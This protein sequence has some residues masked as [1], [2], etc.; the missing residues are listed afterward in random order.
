MMTYQLFD[1]TM[2]QEAIEAK[3]ISVW[4][5]AVG[6][7]SAD[8]MGCFGNRRKRV[9]SVSV[10]DF[11]VDD[12][13][14]EKKKSIDYIFESIVG[15]GSWYQ[16]K[17]IAIMLPLSMIMGY[18]LMVWS[19]QICEVKNQGTFLFQLFLFTSYVP[20]H[21]C[22]VPICDDKDGFNQNALVNIF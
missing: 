18:P 14:A 8:N 20:E 1:D 4:A 16:W 7:S 17:T 2:R 15:G 22:R 13:K 19:Y 11:I 9:V 5:W 12:F 10:V 6:P 21:R 3:A